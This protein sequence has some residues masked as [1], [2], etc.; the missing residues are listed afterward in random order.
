VQANCGLKLDITH[1]D[2]FY[3]CAEK[4][5]GRQRQLQRQVRR[6]YSVRHQPRQ[7]RRRFRRFS[8]LRRS[9][10]LNIRS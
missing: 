10:A 9:V 1:C 4:N 5:R 6:R 7:Q 8:L 2:I 3:V